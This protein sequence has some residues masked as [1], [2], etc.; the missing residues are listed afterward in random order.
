MCSSDLK[1]PKTLSSE[2]NKTL[3]SNEAYLSM[4]NS[5]HDYLK[6]FPEFDPK[7]FLDLIFNPSAVDF[8]MN[9]YKK[10]SINYKPPNGSAFLDLLQPNISKFFE[11]KIKQLDDKE[12]EIRRQNT[13]RKRLAILAKQV[14]LKLLAK[15]N[16][17]EIW[18]KFKEYKNIFVDR[19]TT[20]NT[21]KINSE[22]ESLK[23]SCTALLTKINLYDETKILKVGSKGGD[24]SDNPTADTLKSEFGSMAEYNEELKILNQKY[25][26]SS[27]SSS[28]SSGTSETKSSE[29][30]TETSEKETAL[31]KLKEESS[32]FNTNYS[33]VVRFSLSED[34]RKAV[35]ENHANFSSYSTVD[36]DSSLTDIEQA[37]SYIESYNTHLNILISKYDKL[38]DLIALIRDRLNIDI[39]AYSGDAHYPN[40]ERLKTEGETQLKS[41]DSSSK[42]RND[43]VK[44]IKWYNDTVKKYHINDIFESLDFTGSG[45]LKKPVTKKPVAKKPVAKTPVAKKNIN[46]LIKNIKKIGSGSKKL[47]L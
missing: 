38:E 16:K 41:Y 44:V 9:N 42:T 25:S 5:I 46:E 31:K 19:L 18:E 7:K 13:D 4:Y 35:D 3:Q 22:D 8:I 34:E 17:K 29:S 1:I 40:M 33:K 24:S 20:F 12:L 23:S 21:F 6:T 15:K 26:S 32:K 45:K 27:S 30:K 36:I 47:I 43:A 37:V 28:S 14:A 10:F 11:L 2:F 39:S